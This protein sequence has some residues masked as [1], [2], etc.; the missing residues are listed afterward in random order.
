V[1]ALESLLREHIRGSREAI[2][3]ATRRVDALEALAGKVA[4]A[5]AKPPRKNGWRPEENEILRLR[6]PEGG[7]VAC[8]PLLPGRAA[9]AIRTQ[10]HR[11]GLNTDPRA[12]RFWCDQCQF[13]V[14]RA[15]VAAC[16]S[17]FCE[18]KKLVARGDA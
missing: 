14:N 5:P 6:Y 18:G 4:T 10:A 2:A 16:Q 11:L 8:L 13:K 3:E 7:A 17:K 15:Q 9:T 12:Q 1:N